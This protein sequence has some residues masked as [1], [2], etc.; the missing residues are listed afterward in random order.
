MGLFVWFVEA[1]LY[2]SRIGVMIYDAT[3]KHPKRETL[4]EIDMGLGSEQG[5]KDKVANSRSSSFRGDVYTASL[6]YPAGRKVGEPPSEAFYSMSDSGD[7]N[8]VSLKSEGEESDTYELKSGQV[9]PER[10]GS[11]NSNR[12]YDGEP[13]EIINSILQKRPPAVKS[14]LDNGIDL[15]PKPRLPPLEVTPIKRKIR[16][17]VKIV[18]RKPLVQNFNYHK[19]S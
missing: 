12:E 8:L 5:P 17:K 6:P 7:N 13:T 3:F 14:F 2:V 4:E 11:E 18:H 15:V 10:R 1:R 9:S 16:K 19:I